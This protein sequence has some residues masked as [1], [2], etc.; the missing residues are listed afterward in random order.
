MNCLGEKPCELEMLSDKAECFEGVFNHVNYEDPDINV[1][2]PVFSIHGNHDDP[3]GEGHLASLDILQVSGLLNYYGRTHESDNIVIKPV[4]LQKGRTKLALYGMSNVRDERLFR[5]FRD[6]NVKFFRPNKQSSDWFNLMSV[7]QNHSA[8]TETGYLPESFLPSFMDLV[9]WGHEHECKIEP[10]LNPETNFHVIQPGSSVATSL[11]AGEA[12]PKHV[13]IV[14]I[15][16]RDFHVEPI[17]LR[18]VRPFVIKEM[19]LSDDK[20][21]KKLAKK[22]ENRTAITQRLMEIVEELIQQ[23]KHEWASSQDENESEEAVEVPLPLIR[24]RVEYS[25]PDGG[26]FDC[27]NPQRFSNRFVG[28]VANVNDVVQFHRRKQASSRKTANG[29]ELP[30]ESILAQMTIDT[31][32]VE[33][34]VREF[35]TAQSLTILPQNSFGDAVAQFVDKDDKHAMEMFVHESLKTQVQHL[36]SLESDDHDL[37]E[38]IEAERARLEELFKAGH[39]KRAKT[40]RK[41]KPKPDNW[42]SDM[43]GNWSDDPAAIIRS[44]DEDDDDD[45]DDDNDEERRPPPPAKPTRGRATTARGRGATSSRGARG[46]AKA[47]AAPKPT[48]TARTRKQTIEES[49]DAGNDTMMLDGDEGHDNEDANDSPLF[50]QDSQTMLARAQPPTRSKRTPAANTRKPAARGSSTRQARGALTQ[51]KLQLSRSTPA[52]QASRISGTGTGTG[53]GIRGRQAQDAIEVSDDVDDSDDDAFETR[54]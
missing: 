44:D 42:D 19:A 53:T 32:G 20:V 7:H 51:T 34:L 25:A 46:A 12:V 40:R 35:L 37:Q 10:R 18:T 26:S 33:K 30:E 29:A 27:E 11:V 24:L 6:G 36:L 2:I 41:L 1:A 54:T 13:A 9:V 22:E 43:D 4:L 39:L 28:R 47:A 16:G 31:V 38:E 5:T 50:I 15:T 8:H 3:T 14:S 45:D 23:A 48:R 49:D 17:R 21:A 52:S